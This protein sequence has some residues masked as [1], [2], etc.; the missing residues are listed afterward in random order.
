MSPQQ[1]CDILDDL[2]VTTR[3]AAKYI[4]C[5]EVTLQMMTNGRR[6][7]SHGGGVIEVIPVWIERGLLE[8]K[9][10]MRAASG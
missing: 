3:D 4:G 5:S 2:G 10:K 8:L 1:L 6:Y 9:E 7:Q